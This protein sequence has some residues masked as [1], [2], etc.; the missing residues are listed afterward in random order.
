[1]SDVSEKL[2][3]AKINAHEC[4]DTL[5]E[6]SATFTNQW[7]VLGKNQIDSL[8]ANAD[9]QFKLLA[10]VLPDM[11]SMEI[12][13]DPQAPVRFVIATAEKAEQP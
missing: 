1:M 2:I 3:R 8:K 10:K 4:L 12:T 6:I 7:Q 9:I 13:T 11:K 5:K